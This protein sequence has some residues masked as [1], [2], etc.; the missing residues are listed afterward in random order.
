MSVYCEAWIEDNAAIVEWTTDASGNKFGTSNLK[1]THPS[2]VI[3]GTIELWVE[4]EFVAKYTAGDTFYLPLD[5]AYEIR[6]I[7]E[8]QSV[9]RCIYDR[10]IDGAQDSVQHL[11]NLTDSNGSERFA[12]NEA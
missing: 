8:G 11:I 9:M 12:I 7:S 10:S 5:K 4:G 3:E 6:S 2:E 1:Y